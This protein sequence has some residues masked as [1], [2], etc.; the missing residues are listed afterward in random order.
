MTSE[1]EH[2][3]IF[4]LYIERGNSMSQIMTYTK[5]MLDPLNADPKDIDIVDIAHALSLLCRAN[6]HFPHFYSVAQHSI[7][8]MLE[9]KA[10]GYSTRVQLG[11][12]L[13]DGSEAYLSDVTRPVKPHLVGYAAMEDKLQK[14]IFDKWINPSLTQEERTQVFDIDDAVL[15]FEFL[16]LTGLRLSMPE[17]LLKSVPCV[18][19]LDFLQVEQQFLQI[20]DELTKA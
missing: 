18:A 20:F 14:Q 10:R 5:K 13:H 3:I 1:R 12:L 7:N 11:C 19:L 15:Y 8:C 6:G 9:A 4:T 2:V 16:S 17:P